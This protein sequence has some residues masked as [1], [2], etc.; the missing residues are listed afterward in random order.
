MLP[1]FRLERQISGNQSQHM[2]ETIGLLEHAERC[3]V[4]IYGDSHV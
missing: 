3:P 4:A 1:L 2:A